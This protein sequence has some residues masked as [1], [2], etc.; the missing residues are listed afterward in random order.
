MYRVTQAPLGLDLYVCIDAFT[1]DNASRKGAKR[2]RDS[3]LLI[4]NEYQGVTG[5]R[6]RKIPSFRAGD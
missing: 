5:R 2:C 4:S 6:R 3:G 1:N